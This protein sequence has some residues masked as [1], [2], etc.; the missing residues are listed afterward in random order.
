MTDLATLRSAVDSI[1]IRD[2]IGAAVTDFRRHLRIAEAEITRVVR[3]A[4]M[5]RLI[6]L[7][8]TSPAIALPA[9]FLEIVSIVANSNTPSMDYVTPDVFARRSPQLDSAEAYYTLIGGGGT[10]NTDE[11]MQLLVSGSPSVSSPSEVNLVYMARFPQLVNDT[12]TNWILL[13]HFDLFLYATLRAAAEWIEEDELEAK[14]QNRFDRITMQMGINENRK[15]YAALG[16][17]AFNSPRTVV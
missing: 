3:P 11:R 10:P 1:L 6:T 16:H 12:D 14:Y 5:H 9:D 4:S 15:R 13:N 7:V 2:D 8:M 17:V